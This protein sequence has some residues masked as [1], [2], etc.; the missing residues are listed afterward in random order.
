MA[1]FGAVIAYVMQA[2]AFVVLRRRLPHLPRP[3]RS[4]LGI[5]GAVAALVIALGTLAALFHDASYRP[6]VVG[7][8]VWFAGGL[9]W[10]AMHG[11]RHLVRSP[12]EDFALRAVASET[13]R[14]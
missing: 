6:G 7:C 10:F 13:S 4:R 8:A 9:G 11:R 2:A 14:D 1:V 3:Y 5:P 12:E